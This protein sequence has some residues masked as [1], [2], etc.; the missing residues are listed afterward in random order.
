M[1]LISEGALPILW[2]V[3]WWWFI[4][5][6][7]AQAQWISL[8]E[9][10]Y[11]VATLARESAELDPA[12]PE[13]YWRA[14]LRPQV[15]V[16]IVIYFLLTCGLYGYLFWLPTALASAKT[17]SN[18]QV[19]LLAGLPYVVTVAGMIV[20]SQHSDRRGERRN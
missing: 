2:L 20:V 12:A 15:L 9:R 8:T 13:G 10:D 18:F 19:G 6:H 5:D 1:L 3:I 4:E 16:M 14:L 7:P 11:L 17:M